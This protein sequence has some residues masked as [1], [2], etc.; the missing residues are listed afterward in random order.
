LCTFCW[1]TLLEMYMQPSLPR[2]VRP[3]QCCAGKGGLARSRYFLVV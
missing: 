1:P 3:A 2:I